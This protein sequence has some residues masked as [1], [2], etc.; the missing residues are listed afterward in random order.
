MLFRSLAGGNAALQAQLRGIADASLPGGPARS[1]DLERALLLMRDVPG[2]TMSSALEKGEQPG[3]SRIQ[4]QVQERRPWEL[5]ASVDNFA[6]RY[7][8][9][10]RTS[11]H[12]TL[13]RP[14]EREDVAD[15]SLSQTSGTHQA[16]L[17]YAWGVL[18]QGLRANVSASY[19]RYDVGLD[20]AP[21]ELDGTARSL[22]AGLSYPLMR[23]RERNVWVSLDAAENRL[24]DNALG[25]SLH[26]RLVDSLTLGITGN[27]WD[28]LAGGGQTDLGASFDTGNVD[29]SRNADDL[30]ADTVSARTHG[31]YQKLSW[32][33]A[34]SQNLPRDWSLF[35]AANGQLATDNLDSSEQFMLGGPAGVRG[36]GLAFTD[37][38]WITQHHDA[39]SGAL[40]N[41]SINNY[42]LAG[43]GVG[44]NVA[45]EHWN[46]RSAW[47]H[48]LGRNPNRSAA[49]LDADGRSARSRAWVQLNVAY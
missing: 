45:G 20:L 11:V 6:N 44:F 48:T 4:A 35:L 30:A 15:V 24:D 25:V 40:A 7:T 2:V 34:R 43:A 42:H 38:G 37:L 27:A 14:L 33:V 16:A 28:D 23:S 5:G 31:S 12:G 3:T 41:P 17:S 36:Q 39:W 21:L 26:R 13:L 8:G 10:V 32:H 18:P 46:L 19:M 9:S 49:G 1:E 47:A 22:G 29:L